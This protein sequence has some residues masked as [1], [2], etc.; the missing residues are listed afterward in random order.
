M[1]S[2]LFRRDRRPCGQARHWPTYNVAD[3]WIVAGVILMAIDG[4]TPKPAVRRVVRRVKV[5]ED[6]D[7]PEGGSKS[8]DAEKAQ[9]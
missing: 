9:A 6:D 5:V 8:E 1:K 2:G 4:L 3:I 7:K